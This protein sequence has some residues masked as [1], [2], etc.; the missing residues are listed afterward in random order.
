[1]TDKR[2]GPRGDSTGKRRIGQDDGSVDIQHHHAFSQGVQRGFD[3][4]RNHLRRIQMTQDP[5]HQQPVGTKPRDRDEQHKPQPRIGNPSPR[6]PPARFSTL[7]K[8]DVQDTPGTGAVVDRNMNAA[9][10]RLRIGRS[11]PIVTL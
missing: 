1:M 9:W 3:S 2:L 11:S 10:S 8:R 6:C 7:M 5:F 4:G